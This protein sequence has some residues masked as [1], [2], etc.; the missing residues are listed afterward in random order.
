M[1]R[2]G[3]E[4]VGPLWERLHSP[5][6]DSSEGWRKD[7]MAWVFGPKIQTLLLL[8]FQDLPLRGLRRGV[9]SLVLK[10]PFDIVCVSLPFCRDLWSPV[11]QQHPVLLHHWSN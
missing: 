10:V 7:K 3:V 6:Q 9:D 11:S 1:L 5:A 8:C 2:I 4:K